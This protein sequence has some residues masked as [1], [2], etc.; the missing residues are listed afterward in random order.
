MVVTG[1]SI[2]TGTDL[3]WYAEQLLGPRHAASYCGARAHVPTATV[4]EA[5]ALAHEAGID[6][7]VS[8]GGGSPIDLA[9]AVAHRPALDE[10][11]PAAAPLLHY[12]V[13]TTLSA[14]AFTHSYG[15]TDEAVGVKRAAGDPRLA[16][17]A[18]FLDPEMTLATPMPLWLSTGVKA[19]DHAVE[20][21]LSPGHHP[22]TDALQ[23]EAIRLLCRSLPRTMDDPS[24]L[25]ARERCLVGSWMSL[26]SAA[27]VRGGLS[28]AL[29][30]QLGGRCGVPHG[31]TSCI[32]LPHVLRFLAPDT[33]GRQ[34]M[35]LDAF[36]AAA[37]DAASPGDA[38]AMLVTRLGLP[39][40]L[41]D[42]GVSETD[43]EPVARAAFEEMRGRQT[44]RPLDGP[45]QLAALLRTMW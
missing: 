44:P 2:A 10:E 11:A 38:V 22:V 15:V 9:K 14:G 20:G 17:R 30:H 1:E 33:N 45:E 25:D 18:V 34:A 13:P 39:A 36:R 31:V 29:G 7:V 37:L 12:A 32:T 24:D 41:R 23:L 27:T 16:P 43:I 19:L 26:F 8:L 5:V 6:C 40:C 4:E 42:A 3:L 35:L 28:H 21:F